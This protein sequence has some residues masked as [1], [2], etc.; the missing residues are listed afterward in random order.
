[1]VPYENGTGVTWSICD[2]FYTFSVGEVSIG[3]SP[4]NVSKRE[5][6]NVSV[7]VRDRFIRAIKVSNSLLHKWFPTDLEFVGMPIKG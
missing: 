2:W 3:R 7:E 6:F 5:V 4:K 1:M